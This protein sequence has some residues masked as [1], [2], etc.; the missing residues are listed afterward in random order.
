MRA[1]TDAAAKFAFAGKKRIG[2]DTPLVLAAIYFAAVV[3]YGKEKLK[4]LVDHIFSAS[5]RLFGIPDFKY[6]SIS[7]GLK[8]LFNQHPERLAAPEKG[9]PTPNFCCLR[10]ST[11]IFWV[12]PDK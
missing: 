12:S 8:K 3:L 10:H 2:K 9:L 1:G 11:Q 7:D 5:K 4:L 6:Y